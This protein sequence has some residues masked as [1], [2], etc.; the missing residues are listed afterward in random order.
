VTVERTATPGVSLGDVSGVVT[1]VPADPLR[2][3]AT[4]GLVRMLSDLKASFGFRVSIEKGIPLGSGMGGSAASAVAA[5]VAANALL[6]RPLLDRELLSYA[7]IG[8]AQ[9][10]G[11]YHA[12]NIAPSLFGGLTMAHVLEPSASGLPR[13]E[14]TSLPIPDGIHA[15]VIL[16]RLTVETKQARGVLKPDVPLRGHIAQSAKLAGF[17]S[18]CYRGDLQ[19]IRRSLSDVLIEPQRLHLISGF[20]AVK[21]AALSAGALGCSISGAGPS[22]FAWAHGAEAAEVIKLAML[23]AFRGAGVE[24]RGW[25]ADLKAQEGARVI[26]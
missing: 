20:G 10:S 26:A 7:L 23:A 13:V 19:L 17:I 21:T 12:D 16:P 25:V 1:T 4:A 14:V 5:A 22:V 9:A 11:S 3:T 15:I 2:N 24:A 18:G 6:E 8:E